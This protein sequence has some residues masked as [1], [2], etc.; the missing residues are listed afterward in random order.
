MRHEF[1]PLPAKEYFGRGFRMRHVK[2][3]IL[4][5]ILIGSTA[6]AVPSLQ[7]FIDG[8]TYNWNSQTWVTQSGSFE[9]SFLSP[10]LNYG[11]WVIPYG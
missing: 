2:L 7:L 9:V 6:Y 8:A 5:S 4:M 1:C 11:P 10:I 3:L